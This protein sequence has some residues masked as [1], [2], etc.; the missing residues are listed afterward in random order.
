M[1]CVL[2]L[3]FEVFTLPQVETF[4]LVPGDTSRM[5]AIVGS[6]KNLHHSGTTAGTSIMECKKSDLAD[7]PKLPTDSKHTMMEAARVKDASRATS[8]AKGNLDWI[9]QF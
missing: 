6:R 7:V 5:A 8:T 4:T 1:E 9:P 2:V 3:F